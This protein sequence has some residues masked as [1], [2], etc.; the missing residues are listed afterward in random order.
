M[1]PTSRS[2]RRRATTGDLA[3]N[4]AAHDAARAAAGGG[5]DEGRDNE[6]AKMQAVISALQGEASSLPRFSALV[7]RGKQAEERMKLW[8]QAYEREQGEPA[9]LEAKTSSTTY[10]ALQT[11]HKL[12]ASQLQDLQAEVEA[13]KDVA[14]P[15]SV[16]TAPRKR[17]AVS[18]EAS[19]GG[20]GGGGSGNGGGSGSGKSGGRRGKSGGKRPRSAAAIE[21]IKTAARDCFMLAQLSEEDLRDLMSQMFEV[22]AQA[23]Q[24]LIAEGD[25]N[26]DNFYIVQGGKYEVSLLRRP[27]D[28]VHTYRNPG[29]SFGELALL[30]NCPRAATVRC[31]RGGTLWA[32]DRAT[33]RDVLCGSKVDE[34]SATA[35]FLGGLPL[36]QPPLPPPLPSPTAHCLLLVACCLLLTADC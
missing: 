8:E 4:G 14:A 23:E 2:R 26:A 36:L 9:T 1:K 13:E 24:T 21:A 6:T 11:R 12:A 25:E 5:D 18:A 22:E 32:L 28:V 31:T 29:E 17:L 33:F 10:A 27:G 3:C 30:Y 35:A 16:S 20:R 7:K 19:E 15:A 34:S